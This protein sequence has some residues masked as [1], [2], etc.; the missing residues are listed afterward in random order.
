MS[1]VQFTSDEVAK[2]VGGHAVGPATRIDGASIDSRSVEA[3]QL[4]VPVVAERDGHDFIEAALASGAAAYLTQRD[5]LPETSAILV[6]DTGDA[7]LDLGRAA[8]AL[9]PDRVVGITG[10]VGKT[11]TKDLLAAVLGTTYATA[12]NE[13][14]FNNELGVPLTLLG[15]PAGTEAVVVEMGARGRSHITLLCDVARP[16]IGVVTV[17]EGAH[18]EH[19]GSLA[20]V[21][22]AKAELV[23]ALP[24][25]G[26]AVLNADDPL[27][28]AMAERTVATVVTFGIESV[29]AD[30]GADDVRLDDDL[31]PSFRLRS[32]WGDADVR[33]AARGRHQVVNALAAAAAGLGAGVALEAVADGLARA[34]LS[35][36]RMDLVRAASGA[37]VLNDAYNANPTSM[38]AGLRALAAIDAERR[39]AVIG[40]M[41]E[42]GADG[43][44]AHADVAALARSL[45]ID[46]IAVA[47]P[48]YGDLATHV[49]GVPG[50]IDALGALGLGEHDAVLVKG[51]RVAAL[52]RVVEALVP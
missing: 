20:G 3:G 41:A 34:T 28:A 19:F 33:L 39:V 43:E 6:G 44:E 22:T 23:E 15:A 1:A 35:P 8:R 32:A 50:A 18:L 48:P 16:T 12:A 51:S 27:V 13:R 11:S 21:A 9:L 37:R 25:A 45:G 5:P 47:A 7:L 29:T 4:F 42:L 31:R 24:R 2:A 36:H 46:V 40:V 38:V 49:A 14:S 30:V 26:T 10:S 52:E 17:V